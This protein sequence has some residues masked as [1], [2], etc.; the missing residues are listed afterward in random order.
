MPADEPKK[1]EEGRKALRRGISARLRQSDTPARLTSMTE[2]APG[3]LPISVVP[4]PLLVARRKVAS[5]A[6]ASEK[7]ATIAMSF[8]LGAMFMVNLT[9][10]V[11]AV[12]IPD[13]VI[14]FGS[15]EST[16]VWAV[17]GPILA[18]AVLG[19]SFGKLGDQYGHRLML[20][21][22]L[23]VNAFFTVL[24]AFSWNGVSFVAFRV[25]AAVGA[26]AVG[27]S[28][29]AFINRLFEPRERAS[30]LGWWSFVSAGSPV[31]GIVVGGPVI[32]A[33]GWKPMFV[34]QG[35]MVLAA[36]VAAGLVLPETS[37]RAKAKFDVA[38]AATLGSGVGAA[39]L[40][41]TFAGS[42]G[43][44][45]RVIILAIVALVGIAAF[46]FVEQRVDDPLIPP[47]YWLMR[48]FVVPTMVLT[49]LFAAYMGSFV[50]TP[51]MLQSTAFGFTAA[52]VGLT[53][54]CRPLLFAVTG[55]IAGSLAPR[56]GDRV[57]A[58]FGTFCVA[59][60]MFML[61][62]AQPGRSLLFVAAALGIAGIGAGASAPVMS[63]R[64]A[65]TVPDEDL[66]VAGAAQQM[67]Q[68]FG[69]VV[70]IQVLLAVKV[71]AAGSSDEAGLSDSTIINSYQVAFQV[72]MGVALAAF[73]VT[74]A[75]RRGVDSVR[76]SEEDEELDPYSGSGAVNAAR[77][78]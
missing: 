65:N 74:F 32:D 39:L 41:I 18:F 8:V 16:L 29:L 62:L 35:P 76:G 37:L 11:I 23:F 69:L 20:L 6:E 59:V 21:S 67:L 31:L 46:V 56:L 13:L 15:S 42:G 19:P 61:S 22:G 50:L 25:L 10:T 68:Q 1:P 49:L 33:F 71:A 78:S 27:P 4:W 77:R 47:G 44:D 45:G 75:L 63:A 52:Q 36:A 40:A 64:V 7:F 48:G 70:G 9:V 73:A 3:S 28:A 2:S 57:L 24:I 43:V 72:A 54:A 5:R 17:T 30:A 38:G 55:P 14:E 53:I 66:G 26:A 34:V 58:Q 60:C 12:V 51:L